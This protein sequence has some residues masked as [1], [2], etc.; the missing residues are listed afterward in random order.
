MHCLYPWWQDATVDFMISGGYNVS[1]Q[2]QQVYA[3]LLCHLNQQMLLCRFV[4]YIQKRTLV[5]KQMETME[6][7][8]RLEKGKLKFA[9]NGYLWTMVHVKEN[10]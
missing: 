6:W 8:Q 4:L 5:I 1:A 7:E 2:I 9:Y 3:K 10:I